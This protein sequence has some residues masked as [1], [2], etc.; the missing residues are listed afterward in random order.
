MAS[1]LSRLQIDKL[2]SDS[3]ATWKYQIQLYLRANGL[4]RIVAGE[5]QRPAEDGQAAAAWD[6][7]DD[8]ARAVLGLSVDKS[9]LYLITSKETAADTYRALKDHFEKTNATNVYYLLAQLNKLELKEGGNVEKHLKTHAELC[10][11]LLAVELDLPEQVKIAALFGSLPQS[12]HVLRTSLQMRGDNL[13][14][15]EVVQAIATEE[16]QRRG[17]DDERQQS[18]AESGAF[19][20]FGR[21]RGGYQSSSRGVVGQGGGSGNRS[22]IRCYQ[23]N[24]VGHIARYCQAPDINQDG[25]QLEMATPAGDRLILADAEDDFGDKWVVDSGATSHMVTS[26]NDFGDDYHVYLQP[27]DVRLRNG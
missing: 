19:V 11:K 2:T 10:D 24:A 16:Q 15:D 18:L 23:C 13:S 27:R 3:W 12:F 25:R 21:G 14:L 17:G 5:E 4:W 20:A 22:S 9:L 6:V 7:K 1:E 26:R 8:R